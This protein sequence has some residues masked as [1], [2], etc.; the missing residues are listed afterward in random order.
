[1]S[2]PRTILERA[3]RRI[4]PR[5]DAFERLERRRERK[6]RNRRITAGVVALLV[7]IGGSYAAFTVFRGSTATIGGEGSGG[8]HALWPEVT[9]ADAQQAQARFEA[10]DHSLDWRVDAGAVA[11]EFVNQAFGWDGYSVQGIDG[12]DLTG[13]GPVEVLVQSPAPNCPAGVLCFSDRAGQPLS[14]V[15]VL[16]RLVNPGGIWSVVEVYDPSISLRLPISPG[17]TVVSGQEFLIPFQVP[18]GFQA[19]VGYSYIAT[20]CGG[21]VFT[22]F[23]SSGNAARVFDVGPDGIRFTVADMSFEQNCEPD[24]SASVGGGMD[25]PNG[26]SLSTALDGYIFIALQPKGAQEDD[27]FDEALPNAVGNA[28]VAVAGVPVHFVPTSEGRPSPTV[29]EP[30]PS[31]AQVSC[32]DSGTQIS[33]PVVQPQPDGV[34]IM[35]DNTTGA[36]LG[37]RIQGFGG[38]NA[39]VGTTEIVRPIPPGVYGLNCTTSSKAAEPTTYQTFEVQDPQGIWV[40]TDLTSCMSASGIA[41]GSSTVSPAGI[42]GVQGTP[43]E[44]VTSTISGLL[45]TDL[46]EPAGYPS[47]TDEANVRVVR[48][49]KVVATYHLLPDDHGGWYIDS[50]SA[51]DGTGLASL[52][53]GGGAVSL[54]LCPPTGGGPPPSTDLTIVARSMTFDPTCLVVPAGEPLTIRLDN[55]DSG[56]QKNI[57]IYPMDGC[58]EDRFSTGDPLP[59]CRALAHPVFRG[60]ISAILGGPTYQVPALDAGRYWFQD[61]VHPNSYGLLIVE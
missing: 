15:V 10:G 16:D 5:S 44:V 55:E 18:D 47:T 52:G 30:L 11:G 59:T 39:P 6:A 56:V 36:D 40:S 17:A 21:V 38:D 29:E 2:D 9:L 60:D 51:C 54:T 8:F 42:V 4:D 3:A 20:D 50:A 43:V 14:A 58:L 28:P 32:S 46:V 49:G 41:A 24:Q 33:T 1:M 34:H 13:S 53:S 19:E 25:L 48:D 12:A 23:S 7:A 31:V 35:V 61:D 57:A 37:L 45:P 22:N 27:P 26:A